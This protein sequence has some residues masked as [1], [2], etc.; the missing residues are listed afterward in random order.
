[1]E[2]LSG[3]SD[4]RSRPLWTGHSLI[5]LPAGADAAAGSGRT[6]VWIAPGG[7]FGTGEH[8]TTGLCLRAIE[9]IFPGPRKV[10]DIGTGTG[11]LAVAAAKLGAAEV[12]AVDTD[13]AAVAAAVENV[14]LNRVADRVR[15]REGS[16]AAVLADVKTGGAAA[17]AAANILANVIEEMLSAGLAGA[18]EPG[19]YLAVSGILTTQTAAVRGSLRMAGCELVAQERS[20]E[21]A[22]LL[23][24]RS[25]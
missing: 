11:I 4:P 21:W 3:G 22:L 2:G 12:L 1:M 15:I 17:F 18:V 10:F 6:P 14:R 23:A 20:G 25:A 8:P 19:G 5:V 9:R 13:P 7:A 24:R 16:L